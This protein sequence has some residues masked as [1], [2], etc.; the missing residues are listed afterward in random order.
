MPLQFHHFSKENGLAGAEMVFQLPRQPEGAEG[1]DPG[2]HS[3]PAFHQGTLPDGC[4]ICQL[5]TPRR[6]IV[7]LRICL[8]KRA[9]QERAARTVESSGAHCRLRVAMLRRSFMRRNFEWRW[10]VFIPVVFPFK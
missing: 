7:S 10:C 3:E 8:V 1:A 6:R 2:K 4:A 9:S 5:E